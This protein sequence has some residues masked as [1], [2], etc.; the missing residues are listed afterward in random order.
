MKMRIELRPGATLDIDQS[1]VEQIIKDAFKGQLATLSGKYPTSKRQKVMP[2]GA[3]RWTQTE[4]DVVKKEFDPE[5][6]KSSSKRLAQVIKRTPTAIRQRA[7]KLGLLN[8]VS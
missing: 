6:P 7:F 4:T 2:L 8:R 1:L 3:K 5:Y